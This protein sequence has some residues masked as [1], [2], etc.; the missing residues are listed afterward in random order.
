LGN[1]VVPAQARPFFEAMVSIY[2]HPSYSG[3]PGNV[4]R[5]TLRKGME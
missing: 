4:P 2:S 3:K 5:E 1:A